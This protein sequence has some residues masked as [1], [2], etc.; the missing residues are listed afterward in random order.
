MNIS[1]VATNLNSTPGFNAK[2][3]GRIAFLTMRFVAKYSLKAV[4]LSIAALLYIFAF[5]L[6]MT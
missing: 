5:F 6:K 1:G 3:I 2:R 4:A